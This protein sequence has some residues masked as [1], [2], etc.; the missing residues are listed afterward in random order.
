MPF[1]V[2]NREF[3]RN[4]GGFISP[5]IYVDGITEEHFSILETYLLQNKYYIQTF[6]H[7]NKQSGM[8]H[9]LKDKNNLED[10]KHEGFKIVLQRIL[11][12]ACDYS[13]N[14]IFVEQYRTFYY[15]CPHEL[16][17]GYPDFEID[18][19]PTDMLTNATIEECINIYE[20]SYGKNH[21]LYQINKK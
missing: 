2:S 5:A 14:V 18:L 7:E 13:N 20:Y 10:K 15:N 12:K 1:F 9:I 3:C 16:V 21:L 17:K 4:N 11:N 8:L 6:Y 19:I